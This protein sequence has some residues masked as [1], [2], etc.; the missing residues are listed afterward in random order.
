MPARLR[1]SLLPT[2][3][4]IAPRPIPHARCIACGGAVGGEGL[5]DA[6][7]GALHPACLADRLAEDALLVLLGTLA[8]FVVP[9]VVVW[10]A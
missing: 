8:H 3:A 7:G 6:V 9:V 2:V 4:A 10:A 5:L 1:S